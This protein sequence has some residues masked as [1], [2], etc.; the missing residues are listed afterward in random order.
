[1][2]TFGFLLLYVFL[3]FVGGQTENGE[4]I[5][6]SQSLEGKILLPKDII[7]QGA[8]VLLDGGERVMYTRAD[9]S[10]QIL[11]VPAGAHL[12]DFSVANYIFPQVRIDMSKKKRG[13][14]RASISEQ[15]RVETVPYPLLMEPKA[16]AQY[17]EPREEY[18]IGSIV[19]NPM[20]MMLLVFGGMAF[21]MPKMADPE[22]M[23]E[24]MQQMGMDGSQPPSISDL[25][26]QIKDGGEPAEPAATRAQGK[27][28][29]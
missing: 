22:Q 27:K 18:T 17:F 9:G 7:K 24:Q 25:W 2:R 14:F 19:K 13:K 1:M 4:E 10:F 26:K 28:R 12:L 20:V 6:E 8:R 5:T 11:D 15:G 29:Q 3:V 21:L 16:R 23:K